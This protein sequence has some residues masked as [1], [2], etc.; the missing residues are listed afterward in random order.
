MQTNSGEPYGAAHLVE[1]QMLLHEARDKAARASPTE[2][3]DLHYR[4]ITLSRD[5]G[6]LGDTIARDLA[7]R[8][9]WAVVDREIVDHIARDSHVRQGLVHQLDER[10]QSLV[11]ETIQRFLRMAEGGSFGVAE[12]RESLLKTMAYLSARGEAILVGRGANF[13]LRGEGK[14]LHVRIVA[15]PGVRAQ[16]L[17]LRWHVSPAEAHWRMEELDTERRSFI[18]HLYRKNIDD[19]CFYDLV[20]C[21]DY[22]LPAQ[23]VE[24][25]LSVMGIVPESREVAPKVSVGHVAAAGASS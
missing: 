20:F 8:L 18:R 19:P 22:S 17:S 11:H 4:F 10:T 6:S 13:A 25:I 7:Q 16:R 1:R 23:V 12:Y 2:K 9:G 24:A 21:T 3:P 5:I 15:S 14:G